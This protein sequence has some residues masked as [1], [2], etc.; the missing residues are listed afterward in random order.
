MLNFYYLII[1]LIVNLLYSSGFSSADPEYQ[2]QLIRVG[3]ST[4]DFKYLEYPS[5][6]ISS[7]SNYSITDLSTG[8]VLANAQAGSIYEIKITT[9]GFVLS[10]SGKQVAANIS[11]PISIYTNNGYIKLIDI[12]RKGIIPT[13]RGKIEVVKSPTSA[14]K[15]S[16]VNILPMDEYLKGVVPNELPPSFGLEAL[17]AQAIAARNYAIRPREKTYTQ[18]DICDSIMCQVYFGAGTESPISNQA[19]EETAGLVALYNG[20]VITALYSS[21]SGGFSENYE[22]AFSDPRTNQFPATPLPYLKGKH[23]LNKIEDLSSEDAARE[24]YKSS[25]PSFDIKSGYYRWN[26]TWTKTELEEVLSQNLS[27]FSANKA[28]ARF[29]NPE[30]KIGSIIG[31]LNDIKVLQ[32]GKSGKVMTLQIEASNGTWQVQKELLI[33]QLFTKAGR[34]LPSANIIFEYIK[35]PADEITAIKIFGGGF[36]HGVGMSQYGASYMA[37]QGY[38][39]DKILQHYYNNVA[40]GTIPVVMSSEDTS[41]PIKQ[42]FYTTNGKGSLW[43]NNEGVSKVILNINGKDML[44]KGKDST[45][46]KKKYNISPYLQTGKNTVIFYPPDPKDSEGLSLTMWIEIFDA[47]GD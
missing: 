37:K 23:D 2:E 22:S 10:T 30:Y 14:D 5:T 39:F 15:L 12:R 33:R 47:Q 38:K 8:K 46:T 44:I 11:G 6:K 7:A 13:Y 29:I 27:K 31:S 42:Y 26:K 4:S 40:I 45:L 21:A 43:V 24:F 17:K 3:L 16:V 32:R 41:K 36:G 35:N 19:V 28:T 34:M 20:D 25:P 9:E 18:F 1:L